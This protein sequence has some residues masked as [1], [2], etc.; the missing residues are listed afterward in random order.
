M[1]NGW[2]A[3]V[4]ELVNKY[5]KNTSTHKVKGICQ[6]A[7]IYGRQDHVLY[8]SHPA[9]FKLEKYSYDVPQEDGSTKPVEID[10]VKCAEAAAVGNRSGGNAGAGIRFGNKKF[11]YIRPSTDVDKGGYLSR[12]GGGGA[13]V[14][15]TEKCIIIGIWEKDVPMS[16]KQTQ[17][18]GDVAEVVERMSK[19]LKLK[20]F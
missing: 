13:T 19:F 1:P 18:T 14:V 4:S 15:A 2:E 16:N 6:Y 12:Q 7:C 3:I 20:G 5:D 10:E 9:G 17:N 11:M 8:A